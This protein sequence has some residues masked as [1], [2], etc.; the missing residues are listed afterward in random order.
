MPN[1]QK[2]GAAK[3]CSTKDRVKVFTSGKEQTVTKELYRQKVIEL[4]KS[5]KA[6][7][8]QWEE[9]AHCVDW[10]WDLDGVGDPPD[11]NSLIEE[12]IGGKLMECSECGSFFRLRFGCWSCGGSEV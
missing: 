9:M 5:G 12:Q 3:T 11:G 7:D 4:F 6:T 8:A 2:Q 1:R 10:A